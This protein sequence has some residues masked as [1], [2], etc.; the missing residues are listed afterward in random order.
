ML[1]YFALVFVLLSSMD[2]FAMNYCIEVRNNTDQ[3]FRVVTTNL[4]D[5]KST[6]FDGTFISS[7]WYKAKRIEEDEIPANTKKLLFVTLDEN[8]H[9]KGSDFFKLQNHCGDFYI[10]FGKISNKCVIPLPVLSA[11]R[12]HDVSS[13]YLSFGNSV[14]SRSG[15][16][17]AK[18]ISSRKDGAEVITITRAQ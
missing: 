2:S 1:K 16:Y 11:E 4:D 15:K 13:N 8:D 12:L 5:S 9:K 7:I 18:H 6:L 17:E 10:N 3:P 14:M